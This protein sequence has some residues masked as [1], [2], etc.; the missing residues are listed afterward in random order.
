MH[1]PSELRKYWPLVLAC[2]VGVG[3]S[4]I[5]LPFY[6]IGVLV[7]PF[8]D[9]FG[10]SRT[11]IQTAILFSSGCGALSAPIIG[12]LIDRY[13]P[14]AVAIPGVIG[15]AVAFFAG[16]FITPAL[17]SLYLAYGAMSLLGAGTNPTTWTRA[18]AGTFTQQRGLALGLALTGTG[19]CA[20]FAPQYA[21]WLRDAYGWQAVF[22]GLSALTFGLALPITLIAFRDREQAAETSAPQH[23]WGIPLHQAIR[24]YRFW[25]LLGSIFII[26]LAISGIIP[27]LIPAL[28]DRGFSPS[29]A[30]NVASTIG[31]SLVFGRL[32]IGYLVDKFWA[33]MIAAIATSLPVAACVLL[34]TTTDVTQATLAAVLIGI[35]AGAELDL[36]A[37]FTAKY[38]GLRHY[39]KLYGVF[40]IALALA[41]G[42]AP[43]LF[44]ISYDLYGSYDA[45]F[46]I[47]AILFALGT[48]LV[49]CL[50]RYPDPETRE[51]LAS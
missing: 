28:T 40:Y 10:W 45:S 43:T 44:A 27:N 36:L 11:D 25:V 1:P 13:G 24:S 4:A 38:F 6:T 17:W 48:L 42:A 12:T 41:G 30:T 32:L 46:I 19:A 5:A 21:L 37:F 35:A 15:L 49:L 51:A 8:Q 3:C 2:A 31:I 9:A 26:Y 34:L 22:Y 29:E 7:E 20:I 50:G 33:P 23:R 14:R 18:I 16:S 47:A 39:A